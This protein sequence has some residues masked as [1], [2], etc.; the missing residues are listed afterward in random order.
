MTGGW[1]MIVIATLQRIDLVVCLCNSS[2]LS[3]LKWVLRQIW[4]NPHFWLPEGWWAISHARR[5]VPRCQCVPLKMA[6]DQADRESWTGVETMGWNYQRTRIMISNQSKP[7]GLDALWN[8][9][10]DGQNVWRRCGPVLQHSV[11]AEVD[12]RLHVL[13][14]A[15]LCY[16]FTFFGL[17]CFRRATVSKAFFQIGVCPIMMG[18]P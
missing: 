2:K 11:A 9:W 7:N 18:R 3:R 8:M 13:S 16:L 1:F 5:L 17:R 10:P 14:W 12:S 4:T 6:G 15:M